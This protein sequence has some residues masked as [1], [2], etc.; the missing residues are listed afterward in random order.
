[1]LTINATP[2]KDMSLIFGQSIDE[3]L[4]KR[5][6]RLKNI[7]KN[8]RDLKGNKEIYSVRKTPFPLGRT[9]RIYR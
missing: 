1:M 6:K 9:G 3:R 2:D 4:N 8:T 7:F 5:E